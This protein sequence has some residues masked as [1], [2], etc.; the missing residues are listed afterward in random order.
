[1]KTN[2]ISNLIKRTIEKARPLFNNRFNVI[3]IM[4][5][6]FLLSALIVRVILLFDGV[7][8]IDWNPVELFKL[9]AGGLIY[10]LIASLYFVLPFTLSALLLPKKIYRSVFHKYYVYF[11]FTFFMVLIILSAIAEWYFWQEF[12]VRFNFIAVD[13]LIYTTE[14]VRN[15][16][17]SYPVEIIIPLLFLTA[18]VITFFSRKVINS[19]LNTETKFRTRIKYGAIYLLLPLF[20]YFTVNGSWERLSDNKYNNELGKNGIYALFEAYINN[21]ID[22]DDFYI[23]HPNAENFSRLKQLLSDPNSIYTD[24]TSAD[25][26]RTVF[27]GHDKK[28]MNVIIITVESLSA[29]YLEHFGN[30]EGLTPNL[31]SLVNESIVGDNY[32]ATG[33][34]TV[35][36]I[37]ALTL[38]IPP[39]PGSSIVRRKDNENLCTIGSILKH[40]GYQL[41]FLY[42]GIG[43]FDNMNKFFGDNGF[44]CIDKTSFTKTEKTFSNAWGLCDEDVFNK[45]LKEAD[46]SYSQGKKFF[47]FVLTTSNH[48]PYTFPSGK[49]DLPFNRE[50]AVKYT[51]Y[52][53]GDFIRKAKQR[54]WFA[55]TIFVI[56]ADH[57]ASSAGKTDL[58]LDKYKIPLIIYSPDVIKPF[59]STR[60]ASQIDVAPTVLSIMNM[61]Y[62]STFFGKDLLTGKAESGRAFI[63]NYQKI[64][65]VKDSIIT[66]L[67]VKQQNSF[68]TFNP[69]TL[70]MKRKPD[71]GRMQKYLNDAVAY[72]QSAYYLFKN[73]LL[74]DRK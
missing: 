15:I 2:K 62:K 64:G 21:E 11:F 1:M 35:R 45:T 25:I 51:D 33:T 65:Y 63:S 43:Y 22:Y 13:Y 9:F 42:G 48:R 8:E 23:V 46:Q 40:E 5:L 3:N 20:F 30:K 41:K 52:A 55:N 68:Y 17:E 10:D 49:V 72:Y 60:L 31:D 54:P 19:A 38:S 12:Q 47:S 57:C 59:R 36:G 69:R 56:S 24:S 6:I 28:M 61:D 34:R 26:H 16:F 27:S 71:S 44:N 37:E 53:I 39:T 74:K 32:F 70:E 4:I 18:S 50:G 29:E 7:S 14:V 73:G 58:P 66:V 67:D